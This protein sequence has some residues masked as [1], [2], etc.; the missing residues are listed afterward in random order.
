MAA[1]LLSVLSGARRKI[2]I[3][4]ISLDIPG[5]SDK[6]VL[7][8]LDRTSYC[9]VST[10]TSEVSDHTSRH[11]QRTSYYHVP[12]S[13]SKVVQMYVHAYP[14]PDAPPSNYASVVR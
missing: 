13:T 9:H 10:I 11:V 4:R 7:S 5:L 6:L 8:V 3:S 14:C 12:A 1:K 2:I